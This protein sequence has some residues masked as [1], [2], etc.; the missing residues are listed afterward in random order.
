MTPN[1]AKKSPVHPDCFTLHKRIHVVHF[2]LRLNSCD[3]CVC[4]VSKCPHANVLYK[5]G[6]ACTREAVNARAALFTLFVLHVNTPALIC[7]SV[8]RLVCVYKRSEAGAK[9]YVRNTA[10]G[11]GTGERSRGTCGR[12][13]PRAQN[14][15]ARIVFDLCTKLMAMKIGVGRHKK[16]LV[17]RLMS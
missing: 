11:D 10:A 2:P 14:S 7:P 13:Q 8:C 15:I 3:C 1:P 12:G 16:A 4:V 17:F 6:D 5:P 9:L